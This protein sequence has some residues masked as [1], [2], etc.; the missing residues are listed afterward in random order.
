MWILSVDE[1]QIWTSPLTHQ[2]NYHL[3]I[4]Q[5]NLKFVTRQ[6]RKNCIFFGTFVVDGINRMELLTKL[7]AES[8]LYKNILFNIKFKSRV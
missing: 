7:T 5:A 3:I 8:L 1:A 4:I 6:D 2:H